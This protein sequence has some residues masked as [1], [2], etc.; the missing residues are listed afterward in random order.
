MGPKKYFR[1]RYARSLFILLFSVAVIYLIPYWPQIRY[2]YRDLHF[3]FVTSTDKEDN[4]IS[5]FD[6][7]PINY[8]RIKYEYLGEVPYIHKVFFIPLTFHS[9]APASPQKYKPNP[10]KR[11]IQPK[12][13]PPGLHL[14]YS[15]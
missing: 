5:V 2:L 1:K 12:N 11:E 10:E 14:Y 3:S 8:I 4:E 7:R 13:I 6:T 15:T 9:P